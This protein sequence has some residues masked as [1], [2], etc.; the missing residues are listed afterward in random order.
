MG[1]LL[2]LQ[3]HF[4]VLDSRLE[5]FDRLE[6]RQRLRSAATHV[7]ERAVPRTLHCT[8]GGIELPLGE[9]AVVVRAAV[10]D[11]VQLLTAAKAADL[12]PVGLQEAH[13]AIGKLLD[14]ANGDRFCQVAFYLRAASHKIPTSCL[15]ILAVASDCVA[16]PFE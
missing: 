1:K 10:L 4:A 15:G 2:D 11:G 9:R 13:L 7:E 16:Q 12:S 14:A 3:L 8:G 5:R 6:G